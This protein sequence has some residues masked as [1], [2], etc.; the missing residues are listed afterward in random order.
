MK[1]ESLIKKLQLR[2]TPTELEQLGALAEIERMP[3]LFYLRRLLHEKW[4]AHQKAQP[5]PKTPKPRPDN[6]PYWKTE[7]GQAELQ[8]KARELGLCEV[9]YLPPLPPQQPQTPDPLSDPNIDIDA[10]V[11]ELFGPDE[12]RDEED[13]GWTA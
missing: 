11:A 6:H 8:S 2:L 9:N 4:A 1:P 10:Y 5:H 7:R 13:D 3:R 12:P